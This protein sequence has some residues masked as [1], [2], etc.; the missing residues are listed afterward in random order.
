L[1]ELN[2]VGS[3]DKLLKQIKDFLSAN[4]INALYEKILKRVE[5]VIKKEIKKE[6]YLFFIIIIG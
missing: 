4:D 1:N 2:V 6:I 3:Y 5:K